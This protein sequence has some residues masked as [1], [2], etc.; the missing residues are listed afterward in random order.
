LL[1]LK[2]AKAIRSIN[3]NKYIVLYSIPIVIFWAIQFFSKL[4]K[5]LEKPPKNAVMNLK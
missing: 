3:I 1:K 4:S 5:C 2:D